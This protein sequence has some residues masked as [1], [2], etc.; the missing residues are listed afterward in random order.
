MV[1]LGCKGP[2]VKCNVGERGW[3][4]GRGGCPNVGGICIGCTMPGFP[5]KFM[6]FMDSALPVRI[7]ANVARFTY[8]PVLRIMR[9]QS[10]KRD[11]RTPGW[12]RPLQAV[13]IGGAPRWD[14]PRSEEGPALRAVQGRR[15]GGSPIPGGGKGEGPG[16]GS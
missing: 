8:G 11:S 2:V 16:R 6:P 4:R 13:A 10:M 5:D 14:P 12:E 1:K 15:P 9:G 7:S 3:V